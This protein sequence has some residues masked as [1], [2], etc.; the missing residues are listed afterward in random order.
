MTETTA[1]MPLS[2]QNDPE[3]I[4][5]GRR[6]FAGPVTFLLSAPKV[7]FLPEAICP[8][9]AFAGRSNVGKS[10]LINAVTN[11]N[12]LA[13]TSTTPGRTQELNFFDVGDPAGPQLRLVDMPGYG[14]AEAPRPVVESWQRQI[15]T[16]LRGRTVLKRVFVL[17]DARHGVKDADLP[18]MKLL[19][20]SA[21]SYQLVLTKLDKLNK[22]EAEKAI[23]AVETVARKHT[24][25]HPELL[26]TSSA[27][28]WGIEGVRA[29]IAS[30]AQSGI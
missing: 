2:A 29:V 12:G 3:M 22:N 13:R 14:Y 20:E 8:E 5:A 11:R 15:R 9:I 27:K 30:L 16:Y 4:E 25:C 23:A 10:S 28:G 1:D 18:I 19:D 7:E 17:I 26:A 24:A 6:L 21:V